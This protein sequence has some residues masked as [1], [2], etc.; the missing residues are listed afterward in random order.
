MTEDLHEFHPSAGPEVDA[1]EGYLMAFRREVVMRAGMF[2]ERFRFYRAADLEMSFRVR[3][4]GLRA[5]TVPVP[6][7][8]HEH[9]MWNATPE[10]ERERLSKRNYYRFLQRWRGRLDL[11]SGTAAGSR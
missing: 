11:C 7:E 9:R 4:L 3:D 5:I 2:D 1:I 8:R 6:I 10:P